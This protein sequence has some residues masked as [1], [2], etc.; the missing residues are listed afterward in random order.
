MANPRQRDDVYGT[1]ASADAE[2]YRARRQGT[3]IRASDG[4]R[5][6]TL[7]NEPR[8]PTQPG[9][10]PDPPNAPYAY[11]PASPAG[12]PLGGVP[13]TWAFFRLASPG[14]PRVPFPDHERTQGHLQQS[15]EA[16]GQR[17]EAQRHT[18]TPATDGT[19]EPPSHTLG[20]YRPGNPS[21]IGP[22]W[23]KPAN[24]YVR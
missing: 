15:G 6:P 24:V 18:L 22:R 5:S 3:L 12:T 14:A 16:W 10:K 2:T 11:N 20:Q 1:P 9:Y 13:R 8:R 23:T 7:P 4:F 17:G 21:A 19:N